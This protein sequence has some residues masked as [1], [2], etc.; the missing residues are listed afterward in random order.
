MLF[1]SSVTEMVQII[2]FSLVPVKFQV[3]FANF[4]SLI[5]NAYLSWATNRNIGDTA[6]EFEEMTEQQEQE[7]NGQKPE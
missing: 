5:W 1:F 6:K 4:V 2:N 3:L 7:E